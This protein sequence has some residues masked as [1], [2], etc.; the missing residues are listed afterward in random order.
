M[1]ELKLGWWDIEFYQG[2]PERKLV[3]AALPYQRLP[4]FTARAIPVFSAG[5]ID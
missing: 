4:R 1:Q 2:R 3:V 5:S